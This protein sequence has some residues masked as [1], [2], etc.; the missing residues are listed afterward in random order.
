MSLAVMEPIR[1]SKLDHESALGVTGAAEKIYF[2]LENDV[3]PTYGALRALVTK[4]QAATW[5]PSTAS[6][7]PDQQ[8]LLRVMN[9][10]VGTHMVRILSQKF[11][12]QCSSGRHVIPGLTMRAPA[13]AAEMYAELHRLYHSNTTATRAAI[14]EKLCKPLA[15]GSVA[16]LLASIKAIIAA[17]DDRDTVCHAPVSP[18]EQYAI[19]MGML[20]GYPELTHF[21]QYVAMRRAMSSGQ[22][23]LDDLCAALQAYTIAEPA[24]DTALRS[25]DQSAYAARGN[26]TPKHASRT[27]SPAPTRH[28]RSNSPAPAQTKEG[29]L[30]L[31]ERNSMRATIRQ[32]KKELADDSAKNSSSICDCCHNDGH[33]LGECRTAAR[34]VT[35]QLAADK[36]KKDTKDGVRHGKKK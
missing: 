3:D 22:E 15:V 1:Y 30:T 34:A 32:L 2:E 24:L 17:Y 29:S 7:T 12:E 10:V 4:D 33:W 8:L 36:D 6:R 14:D 23:S 35:K 28:A 20:R 11:A 26:T 27:G 5:L 9:T 16:E 19:V 18:H 25:A 13:S 21:V 31:E